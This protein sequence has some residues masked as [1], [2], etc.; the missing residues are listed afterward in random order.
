M[1]VGALEPQGGLAHHFAR[2][3]DRQHARALHDLREREPLDVL[4]HQEMG[5]ADAPRVGGL[6]DVGVAEP[7]D[8]LHFS[9]EAGDRA[10]VGHPLLGEHLQGDL[11]FQAGVHRTVD[12][13]HA[14]A[15]Q[16]V[17]QLVFAQARQRAP[18]GSS[19][20][21]RLVLHAGNF[22]HLE[23]GLA[24][25]ALRTR[26]RL[27]ALGLLAIPVHGRR[28]PEPLDQRVGLALQGVHHRLALGTA[29]QVPDQSVGFLLR[30]GA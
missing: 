10:G 24:A 22:A 29:C 30:Q 18:P 13:A 15:A 9:F 17:D 16:L 19:G 27:P 25:H 23:R 12:R 2:R 7:A 8:G 5:P 4:H 11:A 6:D 28:L 21:D 1:L 14:P 3:G 26:Q 20:L